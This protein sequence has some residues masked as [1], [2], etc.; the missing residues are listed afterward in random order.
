MNPVS[1]RQGRKMKRAVYEI[2]QN[3]VER[4]YFI[5]KD[6]SGK[7]LLVSKSFAD[8]SALELCLAQIR[9]SARVAEISESTF[10]K[11][12]LPCFLIQKNLE[13]YAFSL[14]GFKGEV[15]FSSECFADKSDCVQ[16]LG[17]FKNLSLDAGIEDS[18]M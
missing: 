15:I 8:R 17:V 9:E 5:F 3:A 10:C 14:L 12:K 7:R 11:E 1:K 13:G 6:V 2:K 4:Y 18:V 16:S